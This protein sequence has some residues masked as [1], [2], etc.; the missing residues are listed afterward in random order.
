MSTMPTEEELRRWETEHIPEYMGKLRE[1]Y[2]AVYNDPYREAGHGNFKRYLVKYERMISAMGTAVDWVQML[3]SH[4]RNNDPN[5]QPIHF[6]HEWSHFV[7]NCKYYTK[8]SEDTAAMLVL[9]RYLTQV[10]HFL[11][12]KKFDRFSVYSGDCWGNHH[13]WDFVYIEKDRVYTVA[14]EYVEDYAKAYDLIEKNK[15]CPDSFDVKRWDNRLVRDAASVLRRLKEQK[16]K[17]R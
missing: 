11:D 3:W 16:K 10:H 4:D 6:F 15:N 7:Q 9:E 1:A 13:W 14:D 12:T 8:Q 2:E 5:I 17:K